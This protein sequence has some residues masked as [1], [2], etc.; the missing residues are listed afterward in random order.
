MKSMTFFQTWSYTLHSLK[1]NFNTRASLCQFLY[2][3]KIIPFLLSISLPTIIITDFIY[4]LKMQISNMVEKV[5]SFKQGGV[6]WFTDLTVTDS[7]YIFPVL[8]ALT[9]W[10]TVEVSCPFFFSVHYFMVPSLTIPF[11]VL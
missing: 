11:P 8:T 7:M 3:C 1:R 6:L 9:F 2:G 4:H 5:P 10:I